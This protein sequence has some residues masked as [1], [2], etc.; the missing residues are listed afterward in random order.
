D[1]GERGHWGVPFAAQ[2]IGDFGR[3]R[4][5]TTGHLPHPRRADLGVFGERVAGLGDVV[6]QQLPACAR[7][8]RGRGGV[9]GCDLLGR[10]GGRGRC[11]RELPG[12]V[13][14]V[15]GDRAGPLLVGSRGLCR[16][17]VRERFLLGGRRRSSP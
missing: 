3:G 8:G 10:F 12:P 15:G 1:R 7:R 5:G 16:G 14:G 4:A 2:L 11:F 13:R 17:G 6:G 9:R